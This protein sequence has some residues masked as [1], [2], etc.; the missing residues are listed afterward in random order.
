MQTR[1][2]HSILGVIIGIA[3]SIMCATTSHAQQSSSDPFQE[4]EETCAICKEGTEIIDRLHKGCFLEEDVDYAIAYIEQCDVSHTVSFL[5]KIR[6]IFINESEGYNYESHQHHQASIIMLTLIHRIIDQ[7]EIFTSTSNGRENNFSNNLNLHNGWSYFFLSHITDELFSMI[8]EYEAS[9]VYGINHDG[10]F[11]NGMRCCLEYFAYGDNSYMTQFIPNYEESAER[12]IKEWNKYSKKTKYITAIDKSVEN[13]IIESPVFFSNYI[14][15]MGIQP[16][17]IATLSSTEPCFAYFYLNNAK[18]ILNI[19]F[20]SMPLIIYQEVSN[21]MLMLFNTNGKSEEFEK[22]IN[23]LN[24][25]VFGNTGVINNQVQSVTKIDLG[26]IKSNYMDYV[27]SLIANGYEFAYYAPMEYPNEI[28]EEDMEAYKEY[29]VTTCKLLGDIFGTDKNPNRNNLR[30]YSIGFENVKGFLNLDKD[31]PLIAYTVELA[32]RTYS[33]DSL[34][35]LTTLENFLPYA[36]AFGVDADLYQLPQIALLY[37]ELGDYTLSKKIIED[38]LITALTYFDEAS[39]ETYPEDVF[40]LAESIYAMSYFKEEYSDIIMQYIPPLESLIATNITEDNYGKAYMGA[41]ANLHLYIADT[42]C[43]IAQY[44]LAKEYIN[45]AINILD[46]CSLPEDYE[47]ELRRDVEYVMYEVSYGLGDSRSYVEHYRKWITYSETEDEANDIETCAKASYMASVAGD[48]ELMEECAEMYME[49]IHENISNIIFNSGSVAREEYWRKWSSTGKFITEAYDTSKTEYPTSILPGIIYNWN[50]ACKGMLLQANNQFD[51]KL[52]THP[53]A[54]LR[55][56][57]QTYKTLSLELESSYMRSNN[58]GDI[59]RLEN[60]VRQIENTLISIIRRE[61]IEM[62]QN[63]DISITWQDVKAVLGDNEIAIEFMRI[64]N[65][66]GIPSYIAIMLRNDWDMPRIVDICTEAELSVYVSFDTSFNRT[67]YN[68]PKS[69]IEV[70]P[71]LWDK[72]NDYIQEG[73][74]V[75]YSTDGLMHQL[76]IEAI[77]VPNQSDEK[78]YVDDIYDMRRLSSTRELCI[79]SSDGR[80]KTAALFGNLNLNMQD[81]EVDAV[82]Q[83]ME[84]SHITSRTLGSQFKNVVPRTP[85]PI[86]SEQMI[87]NVRTTLQSAKIKSD[88]YVREMGTENAFKQLSGTGTDLILIYTHGFYIE[89]LTDYQDN[90][91]KLSPMMRSGVVMA[92]SPEISIDS[93]NDGLLLAREIADM[94][95]SGTDIVFLSACQTAQGEITGDGVFGIQRGLKQAGVDTIIMTLWEVDAMMSIE[96][97]E[98]FYKALAEPGTTKREAFRKAR[99]TVRE[100]FPNKDWAA[101][102]MLD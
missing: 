99:N 21:N 93:D 4:P 39:T 57:Y 76:N 14:C 24:V 81:S 27:E 35:A 38:V 98:E 63:N 55:E 29:C 20:H 50:L 12:L 22:I 80:Y 72:V 78:L 44:D 94:N 92:G 33:Y 83:N 52:S 13:N 36:S 2:L 19:V 102:I 26:T 1:H 69:R 101:Y 46:N 62:P 42:L 85:V 54:E 41:H 84:S 11:Y 89:G 49:A 82:D 34:V 97:V 100:K 70:Y 48:Y 45:K 15:Y 59:I 86:E 56:L 16:N 9:K 6:N 96:I 10:Y 51:Y 28:A 17:S 88:I 66:D 91:V 25:E 60:N 8:Y 64:E 40:Y 30:E 23:E 53:N 32:I 37:S 79:D 74:V 71:L 73:D 75:Y 58:Q 7:H 43:K 5:Y 31:I 90:E 95:L 61:S 77:R 68:K 3:L 87:Y 18:D 65:M 67:L 47:R